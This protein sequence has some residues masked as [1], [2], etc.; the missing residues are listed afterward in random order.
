MNNHDF[1]V[2]SKNRNDFNSEDDFLTLTLSIASIVLDRL[3][4]YGPLIQV[5]EKLRF[6]IFKGKIKLFY[7]YLE[8]NNIFLYEFQ[9]LRVSIVRS[10][11]A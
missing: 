8:N 5:S 7:H 11:N 3:K 10:C 9:L 6:C 1:K 4:W 2:F